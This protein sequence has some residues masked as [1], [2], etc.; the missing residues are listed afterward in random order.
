LAGSGSLPREAM[1]LLQALLYTKYIILSDHCPRAVPSV[2]QCIQMHTV[3]NY[4]IKIND[5]HN[6][7][8]LYMISKYVTKIKNI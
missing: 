1:A 3:K 7:T 4:A 2:A 8:L 6:T 5:M